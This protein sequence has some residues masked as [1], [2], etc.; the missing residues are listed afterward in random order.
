MTASIKDEHGFRTGTTENTFTISAADIGT[1]GGDVSSSIIESAVS[2]ASVTTATSGIAGTVADLDVSYT[3][4][5]NFGNQSVQSFSLFESDGS[6]PHNFLTSSAAGGISIKA[7][8]SASSF[9]EG[10]HL[11]SSVKFQDQYQNIGSGSIRVDIKGNSA[12]TASFTNNSTF[13]NSN[14]ARPG[15]K[16]LTIGW[17]DAESDSLNHNTFTFTDPSGQLSSSRSGDDYE[18]FPKTNLSGS[19]ASGGSTTY[20]VTASIKDEHG[21]ETGTGQHTFTIATADLGTLT[22][23]GTFYIIE[24]AL[25]SSNIF[26]NSNGRS[27]TQGDLGVTYLNS[28]FG[29]PSVQA[30]SVFEADKSTPHQFI[31]S[32]AAGGLSI[33][34]NISGSGRIFGGSALTA[35][36]V[37][38][39]QYQ[40]IGSG[41]ITLNVAKNNPPSITLSPS[42]QTLSAE[43]SLS[44][45]FICSASFSDTE[46]DTVNFD[47]FAFGGTHGSLFSAKQSGNA[48]IINANTDLSASNYSFSV[49]VKDQHGFHTSDA[50]NGSLTVTP[51]FYFY[52]NTNVL[53]LDGSEGTAITQLGDAGGDDVGVTSGSF[54]GQLKSGKIG[55]STITEA[56]GQQMLLVASQSLNHLAS[57]GSG[58]STFRQFGNIA[59]N[60]NSDN[61][62]QFIVLYPSSSQVFQKPNSLRAGLGGSTAREFTVF[63][64]NSSSDQ[65]VTAGLHYFSTDTG[66]K[67]FGNDRWGMIFAL[68]AST[69]PTQFY[70]LLSS[71]GSAPSSEV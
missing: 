47:T 65:A 34:S 6:T 56:G 71:S 23:N 30:F 46:S 16:L 32:S 11:T 8:I 26:I 50:S 52:K 24:S 45:S 41:S 7:N 13:L 53:V 28:G 68:D 36:V 31:T 69:N 59:L 10:S 38:Q 48:M 12:P 29:S 22:T 27:G 44:G 43:K 3:N 21:F 42:S 70:H 5:A 57:S 35:S 67:I 62:H 25:S 19:V 1:L 9:V 15:N 61:G 20:Q 14:E 33:K 2:G 40:N 4:G 60:G 58:F 39:D 17:S 54:M 49:T 63:N 51:M 66:V 37:F 64:D 18:I 55:D